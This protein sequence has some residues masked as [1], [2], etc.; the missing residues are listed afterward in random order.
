MIDVP[1]AHRTAAAFSAFLSGGEPDAEAAQTDVTQL[2]GMS[3]TLSRH[4]C[5]S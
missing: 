1:R 5:S 4:T 2:S 3:L